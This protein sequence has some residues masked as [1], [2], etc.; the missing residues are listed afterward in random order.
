MEFLKLFINTNH[1]KYY[2]TTVN[3]RLALNECV[4]TSDVELKEKLESTRLIEETFFLNA[5][6]LNYVLV[7]NIKLMLVECVN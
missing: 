3:R 7:H 6:N 1:P 4:F 2:T 5:F